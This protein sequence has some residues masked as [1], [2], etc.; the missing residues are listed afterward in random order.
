MPKYVVESTIESYYGG[1]DMKD[2]KEVPE[3]QADTDGTMEE[4][5]SDGLYHRSKAKSDKNGFFH[6]VKIKQPGVNQIT[7]VQVNVA[8]EKSDDDPVTGCFRAV[9]KC[10][11]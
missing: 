6:N 11:R 2:E 7:N 9:W 5:K 3:I 4:V 10:L 8:P 1:D